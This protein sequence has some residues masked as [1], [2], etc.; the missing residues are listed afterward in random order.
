MSDERSWHDEKMEDPEFRCALVQERADD[1]SWKQSSFGG[2]WQYDQYSLKEWAKVNPDEK[3]A[4]SEQPSGDPP[5]SCPE[6]DPAEVIRNLA[7]EVLHLRRQQE[8]P[9]YGWV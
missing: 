9:H 4:L 8:L 6:C 3:V 5:T 7:R 2:Y 1:Q